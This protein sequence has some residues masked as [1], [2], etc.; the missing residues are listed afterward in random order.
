MSE[1]NP[2]GASGSTVSISELAGYFERAVGEERAAALVAEACGELGLGLGPLGHEQARSVL[3][4]LTR[5]EGLI[6]IVAGFALGRLHFARTVKSGK[7]FGE[8]S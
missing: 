4:R 8:A 7:Q 1:R 6:G 5:R 2:S 3:D